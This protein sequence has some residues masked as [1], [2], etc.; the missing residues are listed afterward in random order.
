ML[1]TLDPRWPKERLARV[2]RDISFAWLTLNH[3][4]LPDRIFF[5]R[6]SANRAR[7]AE[8]PRSKYMIAP[9]WL[10]VYQRSWPG[11]WSA[12]AVDIDSCHRKARQQPVGGQTFWQAPGS[13][14]DFTPLGVF[15]HE[16]GHHVDYSLHLKAFSVQNGF[17]DVVD[18]EEEISTIEY[19]VPESFAEA[20]RLFVT[21][22]D[23]LREGRPERYE[24][25]TKGMGLKPLHSHSWKRVLRNAGKRVNDAVVK[26]IAL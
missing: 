12:V 22:P 20:I 7:R 13:F 1:V 2:G 18:N 9:E 11:G 23:L 14:M 8:D 10:G 6:K 25:L 17:Q 21:N 15:C 16:V 26:W 19:N 24:Y 5:D 4:P 3:L